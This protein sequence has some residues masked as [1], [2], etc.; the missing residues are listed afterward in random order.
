MAL[1]IASDLDT[2]LSAE[3]IANVL[4][5]LADDSANR[6]DLRPEAIAMLHELADA[7]Q[8]GKSVPDGTTATATLRGADG[9][10]LNERAN[11]TPLLT[12]LLADVRAVSA[13]QRY[14]ELSV[15]V[16]LVSDDGEG[17]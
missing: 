17:E 9:G 12:K 16:R 4:R 10:A 15:S 2:E 5:G 6:R 1:R 14:V 13:D 7:A 8:S 11:I 3:D